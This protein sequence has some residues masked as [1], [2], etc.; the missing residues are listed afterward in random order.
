MTGVGWFK[1]SPV[2]RFMPLADLFEEFVGVTAISKSFTARLVSTP[3]M[4]GGADPSPRGAGTA[5]PRRRDPR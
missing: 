2:D 5:G 3:G 4:L 1:P